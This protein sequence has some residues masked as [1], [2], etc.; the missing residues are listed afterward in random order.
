MKFALLFLFTFYL[1]LLR[2]CAFFFFFLLEL[3]SSFSS[4]KDAAISNPELTASPSI[5]KSSKGT[6]R[7]VLGSNERV[8]AKTS[9]GYTLYWSELEDSTRLEEI[10][11]LPGL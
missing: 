4:S 11:I 3:F 9:V 2:I 10:A 1:V 8:V 7:H 6:W 5:R